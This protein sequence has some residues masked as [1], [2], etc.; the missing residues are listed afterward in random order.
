MIVHES[1]GS[2]DVVKSS[3]IVMPGGV[4]SFS[5]KVEDFSVIFEFSI[6]DN[7]TD[8]Y[9]GS[10]TYDNQCLISVRH[11]PNVLHSGSSRVFEEVGTIGGKEAYLAFTLSHYPDLTRVLTYT[12]VTIKD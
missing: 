2:C 5:L 12:L 8:A 7:E 11:F 10:N 4:D 9:I 6:I 1:L 3:I